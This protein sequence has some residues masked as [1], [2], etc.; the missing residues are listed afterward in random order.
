MLLADADTDV[1][2][3]LCWLSGPGV[4]ALGIFLLP[5]G[6]SAVTMEQEIALAALRKGTAITVL[7]GNG[8]IFF[9]PRPGMR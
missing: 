2:T 8:F 3:L 4:L 6:A 7:N 1:A 5:R 9:R